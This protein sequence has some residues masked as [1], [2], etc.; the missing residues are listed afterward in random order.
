VVA[1]VCVACWSW[2]AVL[3]RRCILSIIVPQ[4]LAPVLALYT[5]LLSRVF[6]PFLHHIFVH[7][8]PKG[9]PMAEPSKSTLVALYVNL[10]QSGQTMDDVV[11]SLQA[12]A[13][14]LSNE[15]RRALGRA[16]QGWE[17]QHGPTY[18]GATEVASTP[19]RPIPPVPSPAITALVPTGSPFGTR[20]LD[21]SKIAPA[22]TAPGKRPRLCPHCGKK[23]PPTEIYCYGCG[24]ILTS[25]FQATKNIEA[26]ARWGTA[27]FAPSS[28]LF[29]T[30]RG[31]PKAVEV[32][33]ARPVTVGRSSPDSSLQPDIDLAP[34]KAE[35]LGVSR[36]HAEIRRQD[37][38]LVLVDLQ[39]SNHSYVNGQCLHP[40]EVRALRP[41]DEIRLGKLVMKVSFR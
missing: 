39:S 9:D 5:S 1:S 32:I 41:G 24:H 40:H 21:P 16:V 33:L 37:D 18:P 38:T 23:N 22:P 14:Q 30:I 6:C 36:L 4:R 13:Y 3:P 20:F 11:Q 2:I 26:K 15:D 7:C 31:H 17:T 27:Y 10:R 8:S 25:K 19:I 29:L 28:R 34:Y 12:A 35:E